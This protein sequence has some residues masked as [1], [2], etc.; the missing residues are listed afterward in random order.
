MAYGKISAGL[1]DTGA[2]EKEKESG[3]AKVA[4]TAPSQKRS[5]TDRRRH[6]KESQ[7]P[8]RTQKSSKFPTK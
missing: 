2:G 5:D 4:P 8:G 3:L 1:Q 7:V 6:G